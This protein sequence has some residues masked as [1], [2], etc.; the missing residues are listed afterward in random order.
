M[1]FLTSVVWVVVKTARGQLPTLSEAQLS[2]AE[3]HNW[4]LLKEVKVR[5]LRDRFTVLFADHPA[6]EE[7]LA[8]LEDAVLDDEE[9]PVTP[10]AREHL[11]VSMK[12]IVDVLLRA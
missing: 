4:D 12:T 9:S 3:E 8:F 10:E 11:F 7:P 5:A 6:A 2:K 1:L